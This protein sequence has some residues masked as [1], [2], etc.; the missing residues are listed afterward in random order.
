MEFNVEKIID[1]VMDMSS[2]GTSEMETVNSEDNPRQT[3]GPQQAPHQRGG[4]LWKQVAERN[5]GHRIP[6]GIISVPR[7]KEGGIFRRA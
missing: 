1:K 6:A 5:D 2:Q 3:E 7:T 4:R